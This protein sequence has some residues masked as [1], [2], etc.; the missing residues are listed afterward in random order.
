MQ[1][2]A[3]GGTPYSTSR[4]GLLEPELIFALSVK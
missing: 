4:E 1:A 2:K 3:Q